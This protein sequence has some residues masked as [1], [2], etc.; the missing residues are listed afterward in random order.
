[1]QIVQTCTRLSFE[2]VKR[3]PPPP[4]NEADTVQ[5]DTAGKGTLLPAHPRALELE[6]GGAGHGEA[7]LPA[8]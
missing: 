6:V 8:R 7:S 5:R 3:P 2:H 1:M 4:T